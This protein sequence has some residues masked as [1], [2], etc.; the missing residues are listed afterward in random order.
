MKD[1]SIIIV[2]YN[3]SEITSECLRY[4]QRALSAE[5]KLQCEV[6]IIDNASHDDSRSK[7]EEFIAKLPKNLKKIEYKTIWNK[8]NVGFGKANNQGMKIATGTYVLLLNSDAYV[9][10]L[11][12]ETLLEYMDTNPEVGVLTVKVVLPSG[13]LDPAAHRGFPTIWR[14]LTFFA[15]LES[16]TRHIPI[17]NQLF[18]GYHL[19]H[20]NMNV[21]HEIDAP[22]GAFFLTRKSIL[23]K[24]KGFDTRFF[25]YGEDIDL[26]YRIK[27]LGYK[28]LFYP[29]AAIL[30]YKHSSGIKK[31]DKEISKRTKYHFYEAMKIFYDKHYAPSNPSL[32]NKFI[33]WAIDFKYN[34]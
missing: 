18:G 32:V 24:V 29:H 25:M 1:L 26:A 15:G 10:N 13:K 34:L 30:H 5:K 16:A 23:D 2:S 28:I 22:A 17:L 12:F 9:K 4:L 33:H 11:S 8:K 19:T 27:H 3:T 31:K 6:I 20:M 7:I 14:S 21:T